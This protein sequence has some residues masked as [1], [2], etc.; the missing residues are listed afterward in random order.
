[1]T[2]IETAQLILKVLFESVDF[3]VIGEIKKK[4]IL[5]LETLDDWKEYLLNSNKGKDELKNS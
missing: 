2:N 4:E 3:N 5:N 1:V